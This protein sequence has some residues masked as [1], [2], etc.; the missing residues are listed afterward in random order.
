MTQRITSFEAW[1]RVRPARVVYTVG[2]FDGVHLGHQRLL[3]VLHSMALECAAVPVVVTFTGHPQTVIE[4]KSDLFLLT[5][6][7]QRATLLAE[8][9]VPLVFEPA[10]TGA[11]A[12]MEPHQFLESLAGQGAVG[13]VVGDDFRFGAARKGGVEDVA[14]FLEPSGNGCLAIVPGLVMD[15]ERVSSTRIRALLASGD[16]E[17]AA[18]Y[19][20]RDYTL[21][22][23]RQPGDRIG[24]A[25]GFPTVNLHGFKTM[26][27]ANGVYLGRMHHAGREYQAMVYA[28][29]RPTIGGREQRVECHV[30]DARP[31]VA[32]LDEVAVSFTCRLRG[33]MAF[34]D[35][36]A[37]ARQL[38]M[39]RAA[40][41]ARLAL[42]R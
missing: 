21:R 23:C 40:A 32:P 17:P 41:L 28:G 14:G 24:S 39:D 37:L 2:N 3:G 11:I 34:S 5:D 22:G 30:L 20:G 29:S 15:G 13:F 16:V 12:S 4:N 36:D 38:N 1:E 7:D 35:R 27:P 31:D 33:E 6:A 26:L 9:A 10:F 18:R 19:L 42:M 8:S 25:I